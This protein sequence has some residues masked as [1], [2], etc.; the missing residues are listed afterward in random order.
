MVNVR[1]ASGRKRRAGS[2]WLLAVLLLIGS[3]ITYRVLAVRL[4]TLLDRPITLPVSLQDFPKHFGDWFG[5]DQAIRQ[6]T[7]NYMEENFADDFINRHYVNTKTQEWADVYV[8]YCATRPAG[9]LGHRP[10]VCYPAYGW[11][12]SGTETVKLE[13][14]HGRE[15][16]CLLHRFQKPGLD[17][18]EIVVLSFYIV[19]GQITTNEDMFS[20]FWGRWPNLDGDPARYVAQVQISSQVQHSV[21]F[22]AQDFTETILDFLPEEQKEL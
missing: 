17:G 1:V 5:R 14:A 20:S 11:Q 8:V 21:F 22:A 16:P 3:G 10:R 19:N 7:Q 15:I 2:T 12:H 4:Q 18:G 9:I 6:V 13:T